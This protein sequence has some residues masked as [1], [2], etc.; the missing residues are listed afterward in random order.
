MSKLKNFVL[1]QIYS[2]YLSTSAGS[3]GMLPGN[4]V[5][6]V[7]PPFNRPLASDTSYVCSSSTVLV[8]PAEALI[9]QSLQPSRLFKKRLRM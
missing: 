1:F 5:N 9:Y 4:G 8:S 7:E 3:V 2:L 6:V